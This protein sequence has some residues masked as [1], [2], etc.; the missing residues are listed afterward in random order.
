MTQHLGLA[1]ILSA[2]KS[3]RNNLGMSGPRDDIHRAPPSVESPPPQ[4]K[5]KK[6][7]ADLVLGAPSDDMVGESAE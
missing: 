6:N 2:F 3:L 7:T 4:K 5:K 1:S